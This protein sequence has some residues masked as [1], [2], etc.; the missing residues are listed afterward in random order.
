MRLVGAE[1]SPGQDQFLGAAL[2][3]GAREVL[4]AAPAR[5][6]PELHFRQG[7]AGLRRGIDEIAGR[8]GLA[9]AAIGD[10]VHRRD[11][12]NLALHLRHERAL[13]QLVLRAPGF[14]RHAVALLEVAAGAE[15]ALAGA[16]QHHA[17]GVARLGVDAP[18]E[19]QQVVAH[20]GVDRVHRL[21]AV[22]RDQQDVRAVRRD[23][24]R[25]VVGKGVHA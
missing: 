7:E 8:D 10:T 2:A 21:R 16:R 15:G 23:L 4:R 9:A 14:H 18:P 19:I 25:G 22:D 6:D 1:G 20:L 5:H 11:D 17:A 12:R 3:H 24:Q 13:E